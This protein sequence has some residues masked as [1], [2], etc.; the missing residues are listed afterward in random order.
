MKYTTNS[1]SQEIL[2]TCLFFVDRVKLLRTYAH[3]EDFISYEILPGKLGLRGE[4]WMGSVGLE[5]DFGLLIPAAKRD[6]EGIGYSIELGQYDWWRFLSLIT[7]PRGDFN[8][9]LNFSF[10]HE[11]FFD[12]S[13]DVVCCLEPPSFKENIH[14]ICTHFS[15]DTSSVSDAWKVAWQV[16]QREFSAQEANE[17]YLNF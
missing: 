15:P 8:V 4:L 10:S 1:R 16:F 6:V 3:P 9:A 11:T 13:Q 17:E 7:L 2:K 14:Q 5:G 12:A